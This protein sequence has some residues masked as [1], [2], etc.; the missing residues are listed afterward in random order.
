MSKCKWEQD[1]VCANADCPLYADFCPSMIYQECCKFAEEEQESRYKKGLERCPFCGEAPK[2]VV[3]KGKNGFRDR[4][5]VQCSYV[6][7]GCGA[8]GGQRHSKEEAIE[9]WNRRKYG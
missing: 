1:E 3:Y 9:A 8:E 4:F 2:I 7:G 6:D 5:A